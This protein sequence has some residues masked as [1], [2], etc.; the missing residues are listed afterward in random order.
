[1]GT[2]SMRLL[3]MILVLTLVT[4]TPTS[5]QRGKSTTDATGVTT[6]PSAVRQGAPDVKG[7]HS[8][9]DNHH[10]GIHLISFRWTDYEWHTCVTLTMILGVL[11]NIYYHQIPILNSLPESCFL[12]VLGS[13]MGALIWVGG[14]EKDSVFKLTAN[15]FFNVLLPPII[16]DAAFSLYSRDF[17]ANSLNIIVYAVLGTVANIL[18]IG[19]SLYGL[20]QA[21]LLGTLGP[22]DQKLEP[23]Q[24]LLFASLVSAV[25]PVAVLAIFEEI[26]V[27]A[28]LYFLVFGESLFNDG[29]SVVL[30]NSMLALVNQSVDVTQILL[31]VASFFFVVFGG[32]LIGMI[33]GVLVSFLTTQTEHA[34]HSEPLLI[35][36]SAY[37]AFV[38]AELF[39]WSGIISIIGYG[40]V[41]KRYAMTN[42]SSD[43]YVTINHATK[44]IAKSSDCI[45]FLFLG[46]SIFTH[47]HKLHCEFVLATII[48]CTIVRFLITILLSCAMNKFRTYRV[49]WQE[50]IVIAYGGLRGA[51]GFSLAVV[52]D[53]SMW[54]KELFLTTA[55][56][57]VFFTVFV[58]G[59]TIKFL[60]K[61]LKIKLE[62]DA[63]SSACKINEAVQRELCDDIMAGIEVIVGRKGHNR[64]ITWMNHLDNN[65]IRRWLTTS[66]SVDELQRVV[67]E[68]N[69]E[70]MEKHNIRLYGPRLDAENMI[71]Q[72][73]ITGTGTGK[74]MDTSQ[75]LNIWRTKSQKNKRGTWRYS[76]F[77]TEEDKR[78][79]HQALQ[80]GLKVQSA[81]TDSLEKKLLRQL[82]D[83]F[84]RSVSVKSRCAT[85]SATTLENYK[86][87]SDQKRQSMGPSGMR[88]SR[89]FSGEASS[90]FLRAVSEINTSDNV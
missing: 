45:I 42:I 3:L 85:V 7:N 82:T 75:V 25:D 22:Q 60:V 63:D 11:I 73:S 62:Q 55:L 88:R 71:K 47:T 53:D 51:V 54:Y 15:L 35:Y 86:R 24:A 13:V 38:V 12:I 58:Q 20:G 76:R 69:E 17:L 80:E 77:T 43:S 52:L 14:L 49:S 2:V 37:M 16:L 48:L 90:T 39:H 81:R 4:L 6:D 44:T 1:M 61:V 74:R 83:G 79:R 34:R 21:D 50:E 28:S 8:S 31:C 23:V 89:L 57:I 46:M 32:L 84:E 18:I 9:G 72:A 29:V 59:S 5:S 68:N 10:G 87:L 66:R 36:S 30:Y 26:K 27:N 41:V 64:I 19:F 78:E 70:L 56:A 40:L 67:S 65:Y 33:F